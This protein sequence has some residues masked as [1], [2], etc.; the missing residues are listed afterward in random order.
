MNNL[1]QATLA[2]IAIGAFTAAVVEANQIALLTLVQL[3][4]LAI[5]TAYVMAKA[6]VTKVVKERQRE[7]ES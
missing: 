3:N 2:G 1:V 7:N 4:C 6:V 5:E